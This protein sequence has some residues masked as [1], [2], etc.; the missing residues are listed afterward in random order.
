[1]PSL[2]PRAK[3]FFRLLAV[4]LGATLLAYLVERAGP[5]KLLAN[6]KTIG[7]GMLV[8]IALAGVSHIIK[9]WA[10][11]LAMPG[12][13]HKVSFWR[14]LGLRLVSEATAQL[15]FVGQVFGDGMR[16]SLLRS[17]VPVASSLSSVTLDRGL[18]IASG[19]GVTIFGIL[20]A[21]FVVALSSTLQFYA[22]LFVVVLLGLL[23]CA[24]IAVQR[25]WR[26]FSGHSACRRA[27][28]VVSR[29]VKGQRISN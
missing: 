20:A 9:T 17:G 6:A 14:L 21:T 29:V 26:L 7:W 3:S 23:V 12:E 15:G 1:M 18:F 27:G 28:T 19:A 24:A 11:R 2:P 5:G 8:V 13:A 16:I 22:E 4:I 10:W 25:G